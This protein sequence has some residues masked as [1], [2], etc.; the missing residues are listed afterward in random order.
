MRYLLLPFTHGIDKEA[1]DQSL[2]L[3]RNLSACLVC[4][5]LIPL[6][7]G[8]NKG[9]RLE[10]IQQAK[11]FLEY[12]RHR[13]KRAGVTLERMELRT[14][15][16]ENCI[17]HI[18]KEMDNAPILL[19]TRGEQSIMLDTSMIISLMENKHSCYYLVLL[20]QRNG[21]ITLPRILFPL[22]KKYEGTPDEPVLR[23]A[24]PHV[25]SSPFPPSGRFRRQI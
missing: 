1:I 24:T 18:S 12:T 3:A 21:S 7:P 25:A 16:L 20:T 14:S 5:A 11:D 4:V 23:F 9:V 15:H 10:Y 2:A 6:R 22:L 8:S 17:L 13:A 19:F